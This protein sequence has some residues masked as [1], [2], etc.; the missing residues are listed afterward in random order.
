MDSLDLLQTFREVARHN[1]FSAAARALDMSP[2]NV[3]KHV[4]GLETRF[5]VRLFHRTTRKVSLT[6]AGQLLYDRSGPM[7][8]LIALTVGELRQRATKPGGCLTVSAPNRLMQTPVPKLLGRFLKR[9]PDVSLKLLLTN[10]VVDLA[11]EGIDIALRL[12][13]IPD[14]SI[15]VRRIVPVSLS[16]AAT[17]TYWRTHGVPAHPRELTAHRTLTASPH[18]EAPVWLFSDRGKPLAVPLQPLVDAT[19]AAPLLPLALQGLGVVYMATVGL[20]A[21]LKSGA[22]VQALTRYVSHDIWLY[23]AYAQ[24]RHNS[25]A[26]TVLL[27]FLEQETLKIHNAQLFH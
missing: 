13:P 10:R 24:R 19:E 26:M 12:G 14:A 6:D 17:P 3:S 7:L 4:G 5:G 22:L 25:A 23:A 18:D 1:S 2:A 21:H 27:S 16:V 20:A 9:Y 15:I 11:E 8:E